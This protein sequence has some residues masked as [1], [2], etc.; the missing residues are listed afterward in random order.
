MSNFLKILPVLA[1]LFHE[2]GRRDTTKLMVTFYNFVKGP[3][4]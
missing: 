1:E 3:Q 2:D 4:M